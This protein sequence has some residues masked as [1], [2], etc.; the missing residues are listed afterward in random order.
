MVSWLLALELL[1]SFHKGFGSYCL[2]VD[3]YK[4]LEINILTRSLELRLR[5]FLL[6]A[7]N[8]LSSRYPKRSRFQKIQST[9][10]F[11]FWFSFSYHLPLFFLSSSC[12][13][14]FPYFSQK[15]RSCNLDSGTKIFLPIF[16]V[17]EIAL[18][19]VLQVYLERGT[20]NYF[21]IKVRQPP[22]WR[23]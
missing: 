22:A 16:L 3:S 7:N 23:F 4:S 21:G 2:L 15:N 5:I 12:L 13:S 17:T 10:H 1:T 20:L 19:W 18:D 6:L 8:L 11:L 9:F 14:Y